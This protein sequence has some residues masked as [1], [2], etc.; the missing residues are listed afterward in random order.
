M[1]R[2]TLSLL[3][4]ALFL[5]PACPSDGGGGAAPGHGYPPTGPGPATTTDTGGPGG[6]TDP[7][8]STGTPADP[9]PPPPTLTELEVASGAGVRRW[10]DAAWGDGGFLVVWNEIGTEGGSIRARSVSATGVPGEPF[11]VS[12]AGLSDSAAPSV[13]WGDGRYQVTWVDPQSGLTQA[14]VLMTRRVGADGP[15]AEAYQI[16]G[17]ASHSSPPAIAF[18]GGT[19][20]FAW[21][22]LVTKLTEPSAF[23]AVVPDAGAAAPTP[24]AATSLADGGGPLSDLALSYGQE[25]FLCAWVSHPYSGRDG[26]AVMVRRLSPAGQPEGNPIEL[27]NTSDPRPDGLDMAFGGGLFLVVYGWQT[28]EHYDPETAVTGVYLGPLGGLLAKLELPA[29]GKR[30]SWPALAFSA[31]DFVLAYTEAESVAAGGPS[32][33]A[34]AHLE[35]GA[36]VAKTGRRS[37]SVFASEA[38][39]RVQRSPAITASREGKTVLV[40]EDLPTGA[41][42]T[43]RIQAAFGGP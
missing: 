43:G 38:N 17:G 1:R 18:G 22:G 26:A 21:G 20:A 32:R 7:G 24:S 31:R 36:T 37:T 12:G 34:L 6:S 19:F 9:L 39:S 29:E 25:G 14:Q 27:A 33:V 3:S 11:A 16:A 23:A 5:L 13:A 4:T 15:V 42:E 30:R 41:A 10:P 40:W 8:S 28:N 2:A 35:G